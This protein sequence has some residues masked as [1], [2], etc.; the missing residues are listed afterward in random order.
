M[1][2]EMVA[3][4]ENGVNPLIPNAWEFMAQGAGVLAVALVVAALISITRSPHL[5]S[6][7][8]AV[9][10]LVVLAFPF[11]GPVSWFIVGRRSGAPN[12]VRLQGMAP[13][14]GSR[15]SR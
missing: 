8:R 13:M 15:D 2:V 11:L 5:S 3:A 14:T 10:V 6:V 12:P 4:A 9:W 1:G 7:A